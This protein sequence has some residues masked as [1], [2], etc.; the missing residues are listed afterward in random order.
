M[1]P[2]RHRRVLVTGGAGFIGANLTRRL[3]ALGATV[4][5][6]VRPTTDLWRLNE[7]ADAL[8]LHRLDLRDEDAVTAVVGRVKPAVVFHLAAAGGHPTTAEEKEEA[9]GCSVLATANLLEGLRRLHSVRLV[10]AGSGLEYGPHDGVLQEQHVGEP[11]TFR[12]AVKAAA[13]RLVRDFAR[14]ADRP[15]AV[16]LLSHVYGAW[17][18]PRRLVPRLMG[19][20]RHG[21]EIAIT[22]ADARRDLVFVEDVVDALLRAADRPDLRGE[23]IN[24]AAGRTCTIAEVASAV[25]SVSRTG[26]AVQVGAYPLRPVDGAHSYHFDISRAAELLGW[27]PRFELTAGLQQTWKW[28]LRH[29]GA[30]PLAQAAPDVPSEDRS[31]G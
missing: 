10:H 21:E 22:S 31:A 1:S 28:F 7:I 23:A 5:V 17:E 11:A 14:A 2:A 26:L 18:G 9:R 8:V 19:A 25:E 20:A 4:H 16:L 12:G 29:E 15:A 30:Y 3:L 27:L 24:V 13:S 6:V